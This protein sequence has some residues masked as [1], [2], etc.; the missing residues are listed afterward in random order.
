MKTA[1]LLLLSA[2]VIGAA[3]GLPVEDPVAAL[4][5]R[6]F[7]ARWSARSLKPAAPA[8]DYEFLR[9]ITLDLVGR[10]P[11]PA[12]VRSFAADPDPGK[13]SKVVDRLLAS[14]E[15]AFFFADR[16]LRLLF[17]YRFEEQD[18]VKLNLPAFH[19]WLRAAWSGDLAFDAFATALIS[20][21]GELDDHPEAGFLLRHLDPKEPPVTLTNRVTRVFLGLQMQCAQC[22]DHPYEAITQE[23]FWGVAAH[24]GRLQRRT[25]KTFDGV[26]TKLHQET[27][28]R[29][30]MATD[31]ETPR[32]FAPRFLDGS[33][34]PDDLPP[35][36]FL[37]AKIVAFKH[38]RFAAVAVNRLW[39]ALMGRGFVEPVDRFD[40]RTKPSH[41]DL[42]SALAADFRTNGYRLRRLVRGI[43]LSRP[44]GLSSVRTD[45]PESE[46]AF[47]LLRPQDPIQ[48]LNTFTWTLDL[49]VF[50]RQFYEQLTSNKDLPEGFKNPVVFRMYLTTFVTK[51]LSP[52]GRVPEESPYAGSV[53][54]MLKLMNGRDLQGLVKAHWGRLAESLKESDQPRDRIGALYVTMLGRPPKPDELARASEHV[55]R[56]RGDAAAY[57]DLYW[58][59]LNSA[60]FFFNH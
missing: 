25:R 37:A 41:P 55:A 29:V 12:E 30:R 45:A 43:V 46:Y 8:D 19:G 47:K 49:D 18:P 31:V 15:S 3:P 39:G 24:F 11:K 42:L 28:A 59:L 7:E 53:Q 56:K 54:L 16:W 17:G 10:I 2:A 35:V 51:L 21:Q 60:E 40:D 58:A 57:E 34:P 27:P 32:E 36:R 50:F 38:D 48:F 52:G 44:Y 22:H 9:R 20:A 6:H 33:S 26:K 23:D 5:D 14:H 13:R 4:I 1:T